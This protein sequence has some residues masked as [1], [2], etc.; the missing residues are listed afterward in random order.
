MRVASATS[1]F[2]IGV[3]ATSGALV[4]T[5]RGLLLPSL[6]AAAVL[7]VRAGSGLGIRLGQERSP[8]FLKT[9]LAIVLLV[10]SL[11][12]VRRLP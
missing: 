3:T 1:A 2:M 6:A 9:A 11:V 5:G 12:M 8:R 10:V 4:Y 7:G